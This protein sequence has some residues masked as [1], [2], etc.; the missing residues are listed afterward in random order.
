MD[1][2][3]IKSEAF[4]MDLKIKQIMSAEQHVGQMKAVVENEARR[5]DEL[6][7]KAVAECA[8][9]DRMRSEFRNATVVQSNSGDALDEHLFGMNNSNQNTHRRVES[10]RASL[11]KH[12]DY[13]DR[14][15]GQKVA[16]VAPQNN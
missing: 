10:V 16:A 13:L 2:K 12:Y 14:Y 9:I 3:R 7:I 6:L 5:L 11:Q 15:A 1:L 8:E 4:E